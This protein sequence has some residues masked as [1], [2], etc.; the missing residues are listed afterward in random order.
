MTL[1]AE[2]VL[3]DLVHRHNVYY[4]NSHSKNVKL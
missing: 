2:N 3:L 1:M 4:F